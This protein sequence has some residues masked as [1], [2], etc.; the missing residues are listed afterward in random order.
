MGLTS[1][2]LYARRDIQ[3]VERGV[4][5]SRV[6][7]TASQERAFSHK[8]DM[9]SGLLLG[10]ISALLLSM[11][12]PLIM[13]ASVSLTLIGAAIIQRRQLEWA[14][15]HMSVDWSTPYKVQRGEVVTVRLTLTNPTHVD[16]WGIEV[17]ARTPSGLSFVA[18]CDLPSFS[19]GELVGYLRSDHHRT[20]HIWGVEIRGHGRLGLSSAERHI[21]STQRVEVSPSPPLLSWRSLELTA[22]KTDRVSENSQSHRRRGPDGDFSELRLYQPGDS[23]RG[24]AWRAS[25]RRGQL[26]TRISE[27]L[28][29]RRYLFALDVSPVMRAQV[30]YETR[31]DLALDLLL[32]WIAHLRGEQLGVAVFDHRAMFHAPIAPQASASRYLTELAQYA[33]QPLD[34]DCVMN[35]PEELWT[36]VISY[37]EWS[38]EGSSMLSKSDPSFE[39][40]LF[41]SPLLAVD[42]YQLELA[43]SYLHQQRGGEAK[44]LDIKLDAHS[45]LDLLRRYCYHIGVQMTPQLPRSPERLGAG[46]RS[47]LKYAQKQRATHL[48]FLSHGHRASATPSSIQEL[49]RWAR[50]QGALSWVDI[51]A[52][53][54]D[55]P[56]A[57]R[58]I[59]MRYLPLALHSSTQALS[60]SN[61]LGIREVSAAAL[62]RPPW[63]WTPPNRER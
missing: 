15:D 14:L 8:L 9:I 59:P 56:P 12:L 21:I 17:A 41:S 11:T 28:T 57:L 4:K 19:S 61:H 7:H 27:Q 48:I 22:V 16:L 18:R 58:G 5:T 45:E 29:E 51:G 49:S 54:L 3:R 38:G 44:L 33:A 63:T 23:I 26:L 2:T 50:R 10:V 53:S 34:S 39:E 55:R 35:T 47:V 6:N 24:V 43:S 30:G 52:R 36:H 13:I 1:P 40:R 25:A 37:L 32:G 46:L 20:I 31:V 60:S 42:A 62:R